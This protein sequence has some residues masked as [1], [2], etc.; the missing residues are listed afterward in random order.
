MKTLSETAE[1]PNH[2]LQRTPGLAVSV[3][4]GGCDSTGS[5]TGC[6]ARRES[7]AQPAPSPCAA[8]LSSAGS[9][10]ESLSLGSLGR[11][12]F[13]RPSFTIYLAAGLT[14]AFA[15]V[16]ACAHGYH[17]YAT[18]HA[19]AI[20]NPVGDDLVRFRGYIQDDYETVGWS[21]MLV[22]VQA[23]IIFCARKLKRQSHAA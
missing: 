11:T 6:A 22:A 20:L 13:M 4:G 9:G 17:A 3:M 14:L 16:Y 10:P 2:A 18:H 7:P 21:L 19:I 8:V 23:T 15:L 12:A 5:V 1:A